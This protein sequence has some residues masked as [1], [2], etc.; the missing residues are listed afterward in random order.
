MKPTKAS[1]FFDFLGLGPT[2]DAGR[3][4]ADAENGP[5]LYVTDNIDM[6]VR[7]PVLEALLN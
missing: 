7:V 5:G 4:G 3:S 1:G 6:C 2:K